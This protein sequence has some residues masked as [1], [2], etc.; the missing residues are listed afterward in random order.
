MNDELIA[1]LAEM[2]MMS[3]E[4][5]NG[6]ERLAADLGLTGTD[7]FELAASLEEELGEAAEDM[8]LE[9]LGDMTVEEL[10]NRV[11]VED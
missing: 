5:I 7:L 10:C 3:P 11:A 4:D 1:M 8:D 6:D 9:E 2:A